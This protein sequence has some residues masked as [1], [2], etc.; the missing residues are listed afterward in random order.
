MLVFRLPELER[1]AWRKGTQAARKLERDAARSF[2]VAARRIVRAGDAL[3]HDAGSDCFIVAMLNLSRENRPPD[4]AD[5][6]AALERV[7][8]VMKR[9]AGGRLERGWWSF[10]G[11]EEPCDLHRGVQV[12]LERGLRERERFDFLAMLSHELR[13]PLASIHAYLESVLDD[14]SDPNRTRR[15]LETARCE[16]LRLGRMVDGILEFSLLDL[17]PSSLG[18][19]T[20]NVRERIFAA[21]DV[22]APAAGRRGTRLCPRSIPALHARID[23]DACMH[24]LLNLIDNAVVHGKAN[25]TVRLSCSRVAERVEISIDG[26][27]RWLRDA[28]PNGHGLGLRIARTIAERAGGEVRLEHSR[29]SSVRAVLCLPLARAAAEAEVARSAS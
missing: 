1:T 22:L 3:A 26:D 8:A 27:G 17:S 4:A 7:A 23:E 2:G 16:A 12:A 6:H 18:V 19:R 24:A 28:R 9:H 13:T 25:G 11:D 10:G 29:R 15:Y 21:I 5:C 14:R 20:C